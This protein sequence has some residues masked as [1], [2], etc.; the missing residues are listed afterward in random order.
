MD[1]PLIE[2]TVEATV[3]D[4]GYIIK[5]NK[6]DFKELN[7]DVYLKVIDIRKRKSSSSYIFKCVRGDNQEKIKISRR[8]SDKVTIL[9]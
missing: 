8:K 2:K 3:I 5:I 1:F 6:N 4:L 7:T 9:I